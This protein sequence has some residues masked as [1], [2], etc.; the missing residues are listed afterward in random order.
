MI[1]SVDLAGPTMSAGSTESIGSSDL[2]EKDAKQAGAI[3]EFED[4]AERPR[5]ELPPPVERDRP[6]V[7]EALTPRPVAE[8]VP[9]GDPIPVGRTSGDRLEGSVRTKL[10]EPR[11][12]QSTAASPQ[13]F[14]PAVVTRPGPWKERAGG[15]IVVGVLGGLLLVL[16]GAYLGLHALA[17]DKLPRGLTISGVDVGGRSAA[18]AEEALREGLA[19]RATQP[20][21]VT[22]DGEPR[23]IAPETAGLS[24]DYTASVGDAKA[25]GWAPA[26]LW[27][28]YVGSKDRDAVVTV[29]ETKLTTVLDDVAAQV[30]SP[31]TE[32][33]VA[34]RGTRVVVTEPKSGLA[35]DT[36]AAAAAVQSA[37][38]DP[39][40]NVEL[41]LT[42]APPEIDQADVD[43]AVDE[44]A[45]PAVS[46]AV[47]MVFNNKKLT[48]KPAD[49]TPL[50]AMKP[51][52]GALVPVVK[53][54]R[55]SALAREKIGKAGAPVDATVR[56]VNGRPKVVKA[57]PGVAYAGGN[58]EKAFLTAA[59]ADGSDRSQSVKPTKK[60][61]KFTTQEARDLK[62]RRKVSTF[63]TYY[64]YAPYRNVNI[65]RAASL[66]NGT[67][68]KPGETFSLNGTVG[69]RTVANGFTKGF[70][71]SNGVFAEDLGGGVSQMA[72]TTYNAAYF[73]GLEDVEH[74]PH[75]F[76]IDRYPA[77]REA[78]VAWGSKDLRF[79][80]NTPYGILIQAGV[81][82]ATPS[83]SGVVTVSMWSTKV[84]DVTTSASSRYNFTSP[85]TQTFKT[86]DCV[87]NDGYGG[88][89][90][91]VT[92]YWRKPGQSAIV[93]QET[94]HTTYIPAD[95]VICKPPDP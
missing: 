48:L 43:A 7:S 83:S 88:F 23:A 81:T 34:F 65:P 8:G 20:L 82:K 44:F 72:T 37:Y 87:P 38:L 39:E 93:K 52:A 67:L 61:P 92:R 30:A 3:D 77:G 10:T 31:A 29:D 51:R 6:P 15:W 21:D 74:W 4:T 24:V 91:D 84:W 95:T 75:S 53:T 90:I 13:T 36:D 69:E 27:N 19:T 25:T 70:I 54:N 79:K 2:T 5:I 80:N 28:F 73:A 11:T 32:G 63:T 89:E 76:F 33:A 62:I 50:V 60:Q 56:L 49:F 66:V 1:E 58:I 22:I 18:D 12:D 17:A 40:A 64:P 55:L 16:G 85:K 94:K 9:T 41:S 59:A 26:S 42:D 47:T 71:I 45:N 78:T 68:V 86:D 57:K 14:R 46:G 35:L